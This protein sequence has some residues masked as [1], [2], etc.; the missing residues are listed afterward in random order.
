MGTIL[1]TLNR[2]IE[3]F[4]II[5]K[6]TAWGLVA[7]AILAD[8]VLGPVFGF[9]SSLRSPFDFPSIA[10]TIVYSVATY[11]VICAIFWLVCKGFGSKTPLADYLKTW[12]LT[13]FPTILCAL[14]VSFTEAYF[15]LFW[16]SIAWGMAF[17]ILFV[18]IL[19]WKTVLYVIYLR[20]VAGLKRSRMIGAFIVIGFFI[21]LLAWGDA[22]LGVKTPML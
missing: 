11:F 16:N 3:A 17:S 15:Y 14:V 8:A 13:Y 12:G 19:L 2:P 22:H 5:N 6:W 4:K 18:G 7:L 21:L 1:Q 9:T 20:E 10:L